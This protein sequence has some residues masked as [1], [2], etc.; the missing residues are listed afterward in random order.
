MLKSQRAVSAEGQPTVMPDSRRPLFG[1][2]PNVDVD[3]DSN[4]DINVDV[5]VDVNVDMHCISA[6]NCVNVRFNLS[7]LQKSPILVPFISFFKKII[8]RSSK[9][10]TVR[11]AQWKKISLCWLN[12]VQ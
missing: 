9:T 12:L 11:F 3:V 6:T 8:R 10:A 2:I 4:V 5:N 7:T 1:K